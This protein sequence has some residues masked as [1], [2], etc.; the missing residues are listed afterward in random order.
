MA[1]LGF[2]GFLIFSKYN[3][4]NSSFYSGNQTQ[5]PTPSPTPTGAKKIIKAD[6]G[7]QFTL[8]KAQYAMIGDTGLEV[9]VTEF[10]NSP[11]PPDVTC[12]WSGVGTA[13]EA[14]MLFETTA[15]GVD[16]V[17]AFGYHIE[18]V[19]SDNETY[20]NFIVQKK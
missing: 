12:I 18:V 16:A 19:K 3:G 11:C 8:K 15:Q 17:D 4:G 5:N 14:R 2:G 9:E 6:L 20:A 13:F 7:K 10:Y 1:A